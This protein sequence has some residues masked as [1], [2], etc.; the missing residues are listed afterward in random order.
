MLDDDAIAEQWVS[1]DP[2]VYETFHFDLS[3]SPYLYAAE[4]L[5]ATSLPNG[6][7]FAVTTNVINIVK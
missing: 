4:Q 7:T 3:H 5:E 6:E 2:V 1:I